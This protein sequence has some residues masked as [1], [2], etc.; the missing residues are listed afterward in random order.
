MAHK[1]FLLKYFHKTTDLF[2]VLD[3]KGNILDA[4]PSWESTLGYSIKELKNKNI[5]ELLHPDDVKTSLEA[6]EK[7]QDGEEVEQSFKNRYIHKNGSIIYIEWFPTGQQ[8][9]EFTYCLGRNFTEEVNL[10]HKME[11]ERA[12]LIYASQMTALGEMS[13]GIAHE[14]NNPLAI[15]QGFVDKVKIQSRKNVLSEEELLK[16]MDKISKNIQRIS[17]I[18]KGMKNLSRKSDID[19]KANTKL[20]ELL[21][22]VID[23]SGEKFKSAGIDLTINCRSSGS[24]YCNQIQVQQVILNLLNNSFDAISELDEKWVYIECADEDEHVVLS[25]QDSGVLSSEIKQKLFEPFYTTKA[26]GKGTGIGLSVS[27][28]IV[29][30]HSGELSLDDS[31]ENTTFKLKLKRND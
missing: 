11:I 31:E 15:I 2:C 16:N 20:S 22:D 3:P 1:E 25:I 28:K 9:E 26:V 5:A 13:A 6:Y 14:I 24:T 4:N 30:N 23:V 21:K 10:R 19:E 17:G 8:E 18:I 12:S 7:F 29:E 27:K